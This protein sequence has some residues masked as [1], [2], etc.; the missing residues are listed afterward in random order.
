MRCARRGELSALTVMVTAAGTMHRP[1]RTGESPQASS[2]YWV[3]RSMIAPVSIVLRVI[4]LIAAAKV[5]FLSSRRSSSGSG[6][7][8]C[9]RTNTMPSAIAATAAATGNG[10]GP[11][12]ASSVSA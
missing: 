3:T 6:K 1:A 9:L 12:L 4:P 5:L 7:V 8:R 11:V 10:R 2:K